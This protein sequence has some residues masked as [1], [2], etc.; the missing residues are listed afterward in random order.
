MTNDDLQ[1]MY[2]SQT[3]FTN[4]FAAQPKG[5]YVSIAVLLIIW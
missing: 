5:Q 4:A 3:R 2:I 1:R